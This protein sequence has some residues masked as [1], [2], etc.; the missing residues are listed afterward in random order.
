MQNAAGGGSSVETDSRDDGHRSIVS[1]LTSLIEHVQASMKLI[2]S[3]IASET[4]SGTDDIAAKFVVLDDVTPRYVKAGAAL[5]ACDAGLGVALHFLLDARPPDGG[6]SGA[7]L[8]QSEPH[9]L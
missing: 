4:S 5:K 1:D 9:R 8:M 7:V 3:A 6:S 2:E